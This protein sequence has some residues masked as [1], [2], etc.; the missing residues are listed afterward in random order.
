MK[1]FPK[2]VYS[3]RYSSAINFL[4]WTIEKEHKH[5]PKPCS[6]VKD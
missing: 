1:K 5:F 2:Y 3:K 6:S 4:M